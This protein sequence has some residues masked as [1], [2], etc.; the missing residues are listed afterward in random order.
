MSYQYRN[1][2]RSPDPCPEPA[3]ACSALFTANGQHGQWQ[4]APG[5]SI[6][7]EADEKNAERYHWEIVISPPERERAFTYV[8]AHTI[9]LRLPQPGAYVVELTVSKGKCHAQHRAIVWAVTPQLMYRLPATSE[10]LRFDGKVEWAG[11]LARMM[12]DV[13]RNLPT[14]DQKAALTGFNHQHPPSLQ[15]P[16]ATRE[17]LENRPGLPGKQLTDDEIEAIKAADK[18][19]KCNPFVTQSALPAPELTKDQQEAIAAADNPNRC[20][21]FVTQSDL[22]DPELSEKQKAALRERPEHPPGYDNPFIT[23][24]ELPNP[25]LSD[26]QK[27]ALLEERPQPPTKDNPFVTLAELS[28]PELSD[29]QKAALRETREH[30]PNTDNPFVTWAELPGSLLTDE[31]QAALREERETPPTHDNPFVTLAELPGPELTVLQKAALDAAKEPGQTNPFVTLN[32][33]KEGAPFTAEEIAAIKQAG[34]PIT[35]HKPSGDNPFA[36]RRELPGPEL[37]PVQKAALDA[38]QEP[39]GDNPFITRSALPNDPRLTTAQKAALDAAQEPGGDNPFI[40]K[41]VLSPPE[42]TPNQ[43]AAINAANNPS[44]INPF[45]TLDNLPRRELTSD[46]KAAL[47]AANSPSASNAFITKN[48][49]PG[50]ELTP[51]Q[52]AAL[53]AAN[54]PKAANPL[55]TIADLNQIRPG[56]RIVAAGQVDLKQETTS[57]TGTFGGLKVVS[58]QP[59]KGIA[60]LWFDGYQYNQNA[61]YIIK[62]LPVNERVS[63]QEFDEFIVVQFAGFQAEGFTLHMIQPL[64]REGGR[65]A[66]GPCMI[67]VSEIMVV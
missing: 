43:K 54:S 23:L 8:A 45:I 50:P 39:G 42:L 25:E 66:L 55:A 5:S 1:E 53:D 32:D 15:N 3:P 30:P 40:T 4:F 22:P 65:G 56:V 49:L 10:P 7:L 58:T 44:A 17:D 9:L 46:Q 29:N 31:Q 60:V 24:A 20:N 62:A 38:A 41:S 33:L 19:D 6:T 14:D 35:E 47:D 13:D 12:I 28:D 27:A 11:D 59:G 61:R 36:T 16:F 48:A 37:T 18:P 26:N 51:D 34:E 2:C 64:A 57:G 52:K 63:R 21:P 67:E